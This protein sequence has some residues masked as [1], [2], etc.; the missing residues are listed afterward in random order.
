MLAIFL[1]LIAA[2]VMGYLLRRKKR[3]VS[4]CERLTTAALWGLLFILGASVGSDREI[5][6]NIHDLSLQAGIICV[7]S[8]TGSILLVQC[9]CRWFLRER[10]Q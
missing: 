6:S 2:V 4:V 9:I 3:F 1:I 5:L 10:T 7:G 8:V